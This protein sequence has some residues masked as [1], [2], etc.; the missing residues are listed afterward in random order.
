MP[1]AEVRHRIGFVTEGLFAFHPGFHDAEKKVVLGKPFQAGRGIED[2]QAV[3]DLLATHPST[4]RHLA[5]KLAVRFVS[6]EPSAQLVGRLAATFERTRGDIQRVMREL[7]R[8]VEFWQ[9]RRAKIKSPFELAVSSLRALNA[10]MREPRVVAGAIERMGQPLYAYQAPTGYPD[11]AEFWV[12]T[13]SLLNRMNFGIRLAAARFP[14]LSFDLKQLNGGREPESLEQA[15]EV[16]AG[17]LMPGRTTG[18]T[19]RLLAP[20]VRDPEFASRLDQAASQPVLY[21]EAAEKCGVV[22]A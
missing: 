17:L 20:V 12:N 3:L 4:A 10:Q 18:E 7:V 16:Y 15:L 14:G 2:G 13:G 9:S 6:D 11:R 8:S 19:A 5:S 21:V 1:P 22:L